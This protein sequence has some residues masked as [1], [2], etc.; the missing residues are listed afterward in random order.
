MKKE[1]LIFTFL[2]LVAKV[3]AFGR[4]LLLAYFYGTSGTSDIFLLSMTLPVTIFG[5]LSAGIAPGFI[6]IYARLK[7]EKGEEEAGRFTWDVIHTLLMI[8]FLLIGIYYLFSEPL[9]QMLA[10]GFSDDAVRDSVVYTNITIWVIP[11]S[12]VTAVITALLQMNGKMNLTAFVS[13]PLNIGVM[14]SI[15]LAYLAKSPI[16]LPAGFLISSAIQMFTMLMATKKNIRIYT[17][18][19]S[20]KNSRLRSFF[21]N[22][23]FLGISNI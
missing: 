15:L 5:F 7:A 22:L 10:G 23:C 1:I 21:G 16:L 9:I 18:K 17:F 8:C 11:F 20:K 14:G 6:P 13:A 19:I 12:C 2:S 3:I 4:E